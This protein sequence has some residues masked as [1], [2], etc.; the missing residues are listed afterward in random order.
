[1]VIISKKATCNKCGKVLDFW[2]KQE[3]FSINTILGYGTKYDGD[4]LEL[5]LCCD[6]MEK[7][8]DECVISPIRENT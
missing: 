5:D 6:C 2:D 8:I 4:S 1:M 7:L 3:N